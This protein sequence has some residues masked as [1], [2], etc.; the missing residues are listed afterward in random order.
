MS[1]CDLCGQEAGM[2]RKR[3]KECESRRAEGIANIIE[4]A[5]DAALAKLTV[6]ALPD[7]ARQ[8]ADDAFIPQAAITGLYVTG[9]ERAVQSVLQDGILT[10]Q[11]EEQL[12][13]F[14]KGLG[15]GQKE[16]DASGA[17]T[18]MVK[19]GILREVLEGK[20]PERINVFGDLPFNFQKDEKL[21]WIFQDVKY[22]EQ[23]TV[24]RYQGSSQGV[25]LRVAKGVYY[26][27]GEFRGNPIPVIAT[28][29]V[30]T[31]TLAVTHKHIYFA[32]PSKSFRI[33]YLKMIAITP[34]SDGI[35]IQ[36]DAASAKPQTFTTGDGW[37]AYNLISNLAKAAAT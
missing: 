27:I 20:L 1:K 19:A 14:M 29:A 35:G 18:T 23:R 7:K 16:L 17:Y 33:A 24:T 5:S 2:F 26:R 13:A 31:G 12:E 4:F 3:H 10:E 6:D 37:F 22:A 8:I 11:E 28:V 34:F 15:L 9:F 21:I 32:G 36:R 30:D 25:S